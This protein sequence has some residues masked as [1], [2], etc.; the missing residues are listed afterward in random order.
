MAH[1]TYERPRVL[2]DARGSLS[3][4][5]FNRNGKPRHTPLT[6]GVLHSTESHD[7]PGTRDIAG[8]I[9]WWKNPQSGGAAHLVVDSDGNA[10]Y[11][12]DLG[13]T[14]P[15]VG[16]MNYCSVGIEQIGFA[17][18]ALKI[19]LL[20]DK[21]LRAVARW[22]AYINKN[23]GLPLQEAIVTRSGKVARPGWTTHR[24]L[25]EL[26][27]GTNHTDPGAFYPFKKVLN[28][29]KWYAAHGWTE[30]S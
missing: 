18:F 27:L 22:M 4:I 29:A 6:L 20:R 25:G 3:T 10:G 11:A 26:G 5:P 1:Q 15:H 19:W 14:A 8:V 9:Q 30:G 21:Q 2:I 16:T 12:V 7:Y 28:Y 17:K 24:R 13:K 23:Y